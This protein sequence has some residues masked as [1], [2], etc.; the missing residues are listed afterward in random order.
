[1]HHQIVDMRFQL[2]QMASR[3]VV[4]YRW[5]EDCNEPIIA[6]ISGNISSRNEAF[7]A[8]GFESPFKN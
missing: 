3:D 8:A 6:A 2:L 1:M 5:L 7:P 4:V